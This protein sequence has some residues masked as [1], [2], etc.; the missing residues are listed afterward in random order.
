MSGFF[1]AQFL[2]LEH[3]LLIFKVLNISFKCNDSFLSSSFN[4]GPERNYNEEDPGYTFSFY[5]NGNCRES[6]PYT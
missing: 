3:I 1:Y 6:K 5:F 2:K 4:R